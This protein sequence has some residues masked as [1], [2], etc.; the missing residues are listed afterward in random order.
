M[1]PF[2]ATPFGGHRLKSLGPEAMQIVNPDQAR[3]LTR[4]S[5]PTEPVTATTFDR[6]IQPPKKTNHSNCLWQGYPAP[7]NKPQ[8][9]PFTGLPNQSHSSAVAHTHTHLFHT[10]PQPGFLQVF[11]VQAS[12]PR[13]I[14]TSFLFPRLPFTFLPATYRSSILFI[15]SIFHSLLASHSHFLCFSQDLAG[16]SQNFLHIPHFQGLL[17]QHG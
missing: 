8:Q 10:G 1:L 9:L 2:S 16:R 11:G 15:F 4:L 7:Q 12:Q 13:G 3:L 5:N 6:A 17:G 14:F